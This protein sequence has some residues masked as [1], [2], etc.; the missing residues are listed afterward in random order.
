MGED[1][2]TQELKGDMKCIRRSRPA[3]VCSASWRIKS[4]RPCTTASV[5]PSVASGC[6][7]AMSE[8][9]RIINHTRPA[10]PPVWLTRLHV[11]FFTATRGR[12]LS[13]QH[14]FERVGGENEDLTGVSALPTLPA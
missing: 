14:R 12:A 1:R 4:G 5:T 10:M 9:I 13:C 2:A 6:S 3:A 11:L 7:L 8:T